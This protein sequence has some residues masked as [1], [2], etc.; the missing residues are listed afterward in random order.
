MPDYAQLSDDDLNILVAKR[1]GW[2]ATHVGWINGPGGYQRWRIADAAGTVVVNVATLS[3]G[4]EQDAWLRF[5]QNEDDGDV[6][7]N[8][9]AAAELLRDLPFAMLRYDK[10]TGL[11]NVPVIMGKRLGK[12]KDAIPS[13]VC[14]VAYLMHTDAHPTPSMLAAALVGDGA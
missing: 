2:T 14:C 11:W 9:N 4:T 3:D 6:A 12:V 1:R 7:N 8:L 10:K 13:R 5:V